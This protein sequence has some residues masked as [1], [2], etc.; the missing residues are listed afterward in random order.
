MSAAPSD[1]RPKAPTTWRT[2]WLLLGFAVLISIGVVTVLLPELEEHHADGHSSEI[3]TDGAS[4]RETPL[5]E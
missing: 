1:P 2:V 5:Q 3:E 4:S